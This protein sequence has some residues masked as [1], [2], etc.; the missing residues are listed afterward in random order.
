MNRYEESVTREM[1]NLEERLK[2]KR[3]EMK[4]IQNTIQTGQTMRAELDNERDLVKSIRS[5]VKYY[6]KDLPHRARF[7]PELLE[8]VSRTVS[9]DVFIESLEEIEPYHLDLKGWALSD[10]TAQ[11]FYRSLCRE[12]EK[13]GLVMLEGSTL[14]Q[15]GSVG[16][17]AYTLHA[18][19]GP[20]KEEER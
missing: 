6:E 7:L 15:E 12:F 8:V 2:V 5:Q 17:G 9:E 4:N 18:V 16:A 13:L 14:V 20:A 19:F 10:L 3:L 1:E 11:R